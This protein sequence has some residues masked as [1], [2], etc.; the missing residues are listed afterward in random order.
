MR[1]KFY[2]FS[3]LCSTGPPENHYIFYSRFSHMTSH[4]TEQDKH[5]MR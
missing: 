4:V 5:H 3:A 1:L 2:N